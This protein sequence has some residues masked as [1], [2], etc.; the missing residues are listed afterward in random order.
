MTSPEVDI[1]KD[2]NEAQR[3][4]VTWPPEKPLL[5]LAGA[6]SGKTRI[7]T[8]RIAYL[9]LQ[10]VPSFQVLGVTF[11]NKAAEEM[12]R[13][14]RQLVRHEVWVSTFHSGCLKILREEAAALELPRDFLIY[15]DQDQLAL[16]KDCLKQMNLPERRVH[17]KGAREMIQRAKDYLL[18]PLQVIEKAVDDY[19]ETVGKVYERYEQR[20]RELGALD[21]GDLILKTV[22][23]FDRHPKILEGWQDRLR[24]VLI[25]EY[26]DTNHA[27]YRFVKLLASRHRQITV[28]GDP[29]QS[30]YAWRGADIKNILNF[31]KDYPEAGVIKMEQNYRSPAT[32]LDAANELIRHNEF[33]KPK[34]LWGE[35]GVGGKITL[36]EAE[37]EKDEG[38]FVVT[39]ILN[40]KNQGRTFNEMV[41][42]YR[43]HAQSRVLEDACRRA[44]IPYKIVGGIRFYDRREIKDLMAYLRLV[45]Q[46]K[47]EISLKRVLNVPTRGIGKRAVEFIEAHGRQNQI[48]FVEA[49]AQAGKVPELGAKAVKGI[50]GFLKLLA[51]LRKL[52]GKVSVRSLLEKI[53]ERTGYV[54]LLAQ[55]RTIEAAAR[56][57][58]IEEFFSVIDEYEENAENP[59]LGEFLESLSLLTDIDTWD[60]GANCLTLMTLHSAKGLEFPL[61]FMVGMEAG[62][63]P[64]ANSMGGGAEEMEE[65]RRLCYVGITRTQEKLYLSYAISRRL[66]GRQARNLPSRFLSEIPP[67]L[68]EFRSPFGAPE[69][70]LE[71][72]SS[73]EEIRIDY[74][75]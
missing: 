56:I 36:Y 20:M 44:K 29:D 33:R 17:P 46:P 12:R 61:V 60:A 41:V 8:R 14:V 40:F 27:Q 24:H 23:L 19:E 11:T 37:D 15:D 71:K 68:M 39:E 10:G 52:K 75:S 45:V 66:Y 65:E 74:D 34:L 25:D 72:E 54:E 32:I 9:L 62:L 2:L 3:Q 57:E 6:G 31:E 70:E 7:L 42:F 30:I 63:F 48:S 28:V 47:D 59:G 69:I 35:K 55:E 18:S 21:F 38:N 4:A 5:V 53:I 22:F 58:N 73:S 16:I 1:L 51:E 64:H 43:V 26:Q 67:E 50:E 49:L 13:R